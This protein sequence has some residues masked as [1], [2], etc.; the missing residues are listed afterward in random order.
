MEIFF[1][2]KIKK[3]NIK[4]S[5]KKNLKNKKNLEKLFKFF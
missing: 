1:R 2:K 3:K 4:I 5:E